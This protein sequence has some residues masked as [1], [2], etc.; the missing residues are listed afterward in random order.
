MNVLLITSRSDQG[1]GPRHVYD[2]ACYLKN[3]GH[4]VYI[5]SPLTNPFGSLFCE[6]FAGHIEIP[7]R[8]FCLRAW[9]KLLMFAREKG[10][11]VIHSHGKGAGIYSRP[12]A[13][14]GFKIIH[15]FHGL[16]LKPGI[17]GKLNSLV[18]RFL[19]TFTKKIIC[20]AE[21]ERGKAISI[22][23]SAKN[24]SV[25]GNGIKGFEVT[26]NQIPWEERPIILGTLSRL[27]PHKGNL[28]L[29]EKFQTLPEHYHLKI[30][31]EGEERE[32]LNSYIQ[33]HQLQSRV[34]LVGEVA[35]PV[36]FLESIDIY[37][38]CSKGE[39]LPYA[40]LEAIIALKPVVASRVSG[41]IE[42][43]NE[44]QL[45]SGRDDFKERIELASNQDVK[46]SR[47]VILKNYELSVSCKK[48]ETL[49]QEL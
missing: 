45:F 40:I 10:I 17:K 27:D 1:G 6:Q 9:F 42:L 20:V 11:A 25:I 47:E 16:H 4:Q 12:L 46:K 41:H 21:S 34:T 48:I 29:L 19:S 32:M 23:I 44:N 13:I 30:A 8:R 37:V 31:G 35:A 3:Q 7:H 15:T 5:A 49:Y 24:L 38:S 36:S 2:L 18:E 28:E 14:F 33:S 22:G 26:Q 43:L 39:G